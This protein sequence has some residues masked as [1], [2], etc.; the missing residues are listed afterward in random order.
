MEIT[1]TV[2]YSLFV[3]DNEMKDIA[4]IARYYMQEG[5]SQEEA[6]EWAVRNYIAGQDDAIFYSITEEAIEQIEAEVN[7]LLTEQGIDKF[8]FR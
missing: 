8:P 5:N 4:D 6:I 3:S 2:E 7:K 1:W